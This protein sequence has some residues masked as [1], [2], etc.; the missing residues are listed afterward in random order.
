MERV[1]AVVTMPTDCLHFVYQY[2]AL[3]VTL[4]STIALV[5]KMSSGDIL[6]T[7]FHLSCGLAALCSCCKQSGMS[8]VLTNIDKGVST[9]V[10]HIPRIKAQ[11]GT[12][13]RHQKT[14]G[15]KMS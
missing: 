8:R 4:L 15:R 3:S 6:C 1:S 2:Y 14:G 12:T 5:T 13:I 9:A 11:I 10:F 7:S